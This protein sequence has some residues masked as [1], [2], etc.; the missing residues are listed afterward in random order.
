MADAPLAIHKHKPI[1]PNELSDH[2][3]EPLNE[4][5]FRGHVNRL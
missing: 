5:Q 3:K 2:G 1:V 4:H